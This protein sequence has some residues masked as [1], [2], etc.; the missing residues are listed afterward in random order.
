M[1]NYYHSSFYAM[2]TRCHLV[3]PGLDD[4]IGEQIFTVIKQEVN[5]IET[6]LSRFIPYSEISAINRQAAEEAVEV[7]PE[8]Y[9]ILKTCRHY[10]ELTDGAFDITLRP[11]LQYWK[12]K[13]DDP[14][15]DERLDELRKSL[16]MKYVHLDDATQTVRFDNALLEIDLGGYGK[17]YA[18]EQVQ[19]RLHEF[20]V[21][22]AFVSFGES[23][24]LTLGRHP[25]GDHWKVGLNDYLNPGVALHTFA[26]NESAVSTSSNFYVDDSG[27][28]H[29]HRHVIDPFTGRPIGKCITASVCAESS[30]SAEILSTAFLI[31]SDDAI[32]TM[33]T[34]F[35]PCDIIKVD[36]TGGRPEISSV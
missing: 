13:N 9:E 18:L 20:S 19:K 4:D 27:A 1:K 6:S 10:Y 29:N 14:E 30:V 23:S 25:A 32:R 24:I 36:Y 2:G 17:G 16:G 3:F 8:I 26:V 35:D 31:A 28:L 11:L 33:R 15:G 21:K 34:R 5:R 7:S 22:N 12:E